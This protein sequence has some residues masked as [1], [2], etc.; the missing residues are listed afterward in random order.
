MF[1]VA[2][3]VGVLRSLGPSLLVT[4]QL[5]KPT[6][7]PTYIIL[8]LYVLMPIINLEIILGKLKYKICSQPNFLILV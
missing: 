7:I 5:I 6:R 2:Q 1:G 8:V 4:A 3:A